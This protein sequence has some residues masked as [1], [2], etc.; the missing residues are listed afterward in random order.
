M[1]GGTAPRKDLTARL[2]AALAELRP[3]LRREGVDL[4]L[5]EVDPAGTARLAV[6]SLDLACPADL[7]SLR[8]DLKRRLQERVPE[9]R[10]VVA[11]TEGSDEEYEL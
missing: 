2:E 8:R 9:L 11:V 7:G 4:E 10:A 3:A 6:I 1:D 5:V